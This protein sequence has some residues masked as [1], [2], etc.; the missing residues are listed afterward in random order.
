M[1]SHVAD[2]PPFFHAVGLRHR[3]RGCPDKTP[4]RHQNACIDL[5]SVLCGN[6]AVFLQKILADDPHI[7][8]AHLRY[9]QIS[10]KDSSIYRQTTLQHFLKNLRNF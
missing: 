2:S 5:H 3:A 8:Q 6:V 9:I 7:P 1:D 10:R 4:G